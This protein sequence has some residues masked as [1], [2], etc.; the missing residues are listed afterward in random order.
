MEY[1]IESTKTTKFQLEDK[2]DVN[3]SKN[4]KTF[5]LCVQWYRELLRYLYELKN[6]NVFYQPESNGNNGVYRYNMGEIGYLT[7]YIIE[8]NNDIIIYILDF[9]FNNY[10]I[11]EYINKFNSLL[12]E[13]NKGSWKK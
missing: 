3:F 11:L 4:R 2:L 13:M 7:Y 9:Y 5:N 8:N 1:R 10:G 12:D 6:P